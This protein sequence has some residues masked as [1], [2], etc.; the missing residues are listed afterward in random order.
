MSVAPE[1]RKPWR[2]YK[3]AVASLAQRIVDAQ[4]PIRILNSI[5]WPSTVFESFRQSKWRE[6]PPLDPAYYATLSQDYDLAAKEREFAEI[7]SDVRT[8]LGDDPIGRILLHTAEQ[9]IGVLEMLRS[10]GTKRFYT[11]SRELY[12]SPKDVLQDGETAVRDVAQRM[13]QLLTQLDDRVLGPVPELTLSAEQAVEILNRRLAE[14]FDDVMVRVILD[15]GIVADA[16]AGSDY[17]KVR[18][19]A[20]FSERDVKILE[21]HEGWVHVA[22]SVNG[23]RQPVARWLAV[24]PPRV[25]AT[26]EGLAT[27]TEVLTLCSHPRRARRLNDRSLAVDKA[28]DGA[29]FF[30]VFEWFRTEGYDESTCYWSAQRVFRGG[31]VGG[32]APFTKDVSY[33][34][35]LVSN[36]N[37]LRSAI[38]G[39]RPDL[40]RW[41]FAGKVALE[42]I[43]ILAARAH[44]GVVAVPRYMP[45]MFQDL[46]G[47][48]MW[49]GVSAFWAYVNNEKIQT[50]YNKLFQTG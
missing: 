12:G 30:E 24:G 35:G 47:L 18:S 48:A 40:I 36:F 44:E 49:L 43:P 2:S 14:V 29:S 33:V 50:Y 9:Y 26:Q 10:R 8:D 21:V 15:D 20:R 13:Y 4:R 28:E 38:T 32:A 7:A 34:K 37:F 11:L 46:N 27:L 23:Q 1:A 42:D 31:V 19:D 6:L 45:P 25:A 41:L 16:A 3:E 17:I 22:T 5:K 39:G